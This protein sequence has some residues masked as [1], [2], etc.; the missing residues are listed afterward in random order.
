MMASEVS[1]TTELQ[2]ES[3]AKDVVVVFEGGGLKGI[4]LVGAYSALEERD[5]RPQNMAGASAGAIVAAL[6]AAEFLSSGW[7][8][9]AP[10]RGSRKEDHVHPRV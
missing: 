4:A 3:R 5:F 6:V 10:G 1:P 9:P 2:T 7:H 8:T